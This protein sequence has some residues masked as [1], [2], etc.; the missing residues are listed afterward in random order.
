MNPTSTPRLRAEPTLRPTVAEID[1]DAFAM[2]TARVRSLLG[3][4][5]R[6]MAVVKADGYGHGAAEVAGTSVAAGSEMLGVGVLEEG[7]ELRRAGVAAPILVL[8]GALAEQAAS[9]AA[10]DFEVVLCDA[11]LAEAL[12]AAGI[13]AGRPISVHVK[14]DT[15][16]GRLGV[17]PGEAAAFL[18]RLADLG[19]ISIRGLMSH[20]ADAEDPAGGSPRQMKTFLDLAGSL[21]ERGL[22]PPVLHC[23]NS[24]AV[25]TLPDSR[26]DMARV[27]ILLYGVSPRP[28]RPEDGFLPVMSWKSRVVHV[29]EAADPRTVGYGRA[30]RTPGASRIAIVPMGYADGYPRVLSNKADVLV[31]GRR[32]PVV[33]AVSMDMLAVSVGHLPDVSVGEEVVLLGAQGGE[34]VTAEELADLADTVPYEILCGLSRRVPRVYREGGR[35]VRATYPDALFP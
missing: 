20:F 11:E 13:A 12:S 24:G 27:G 35:V 16:M 3:R 26:L 9:V 25:L 8:G 18:G 22:L 32:A 2:N 19:G 1:L 23:A 15:G 30:Y 31:R 14:V 33:G 17:Q 21:R 6:L 29:N 7:W 28:G 10:G 5:T 4:S 34:R